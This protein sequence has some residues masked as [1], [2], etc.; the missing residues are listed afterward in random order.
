MLILCKKNWKI[1]VFT[2]FCS[3]I[4]AVLEN[5]NM[6]SVGGGCVFGKPALGQKRSNS[7]QNLKHLDKR[8][9]PPLWGHE[10]LGWRQGPT[11]RG[12]GPLGLGQRPPGQEQRLLGHG[13]GHPGWEQEPNWK[14]RDLLYK[15]RDLLVDGRD[16]LAKD[17]DL[18][19][20]GKDLLD[21]GRDLLDL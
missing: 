8:K 14:G 15:G 10:P 21:E 17:R 13:K 1:I 20:E 12:Q 18:L 9:V 2:V 16:L 5:R 4:Y 6:G 11:R 19:E 3:T 7:F